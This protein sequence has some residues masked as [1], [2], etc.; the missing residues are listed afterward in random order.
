MKPNIVGIFIIFILLLFFL[1]SNSSRMERF[2]IQKS[3]KLN[4]KVQDKIPKTIFTN[5]IT[6]EM[7][8]KNATGKI[9]TTAKIE[10]DFFLS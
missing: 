1:L 3:E 6:S 7:A 10:Q 8:Q 5:I 9:F 2:Q 4:N